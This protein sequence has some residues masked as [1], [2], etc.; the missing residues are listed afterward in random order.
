VAACE[1][2]RMSNT[3]SHREFEER[4]E[5]LVREHI[6]LL[7]RSAR[8]ALERAFASTAPSPTRKAAPARVAVRAA[9]GASRRRAPAEVSAI[10]ERLYQ[11]VCAHPGESMATLAKEL[12]TAPRELQRPMALLREAGRVRCVGQR[13]LMRYFPRTSASS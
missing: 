9:A 10:G 5:Q 7:Q 6:V 12:A 1:A 8:E 11:A 13:H 2:H 4:I 3:T